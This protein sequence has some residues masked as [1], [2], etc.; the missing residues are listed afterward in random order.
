MVDSPTAAGVF[1]VLHE[2]KVCR[3]PIWGGVDEE[4]VQWICDGC[5]RTFAG[6]GHSKA[7]NGGEALIEYWKH[8]LETVDDPAGPEARLCADMLAAL[9]IVRDAEDGVVAAPNVKEETPCH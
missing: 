7:K 6:C 9:E 2:C 3:C 5:G 1:H 8:Q 4:R